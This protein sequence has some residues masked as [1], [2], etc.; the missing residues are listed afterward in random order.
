MKNEDDTTKYGDLRPGFYCSYGDT[1]CKVIESK[2]DRQCDLP[3]GHQGRHIAGCLLFAN[4]QV[5]WSD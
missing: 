3:F 1:R 2:S 4:F 5:E